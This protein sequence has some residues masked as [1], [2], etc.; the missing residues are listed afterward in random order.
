M[1]RRC[2]YVTLSPIF[3]SPSKPAYGPALGIE[4]LAAT[5]AQVRIPVLALGGVDATN[6]R[7]C[8]DAGAAGAAVM[9]GIMGADDPAGMAQA[10]IEAL[11]R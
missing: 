5:A 4:A 3:P 1:H 9:G 11:Q 10:L 6:L 8:L 7:A 2:D